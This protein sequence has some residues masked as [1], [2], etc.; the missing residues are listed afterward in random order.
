MAK[1][2][3]IID[4]LGYNY[5]RNKNSITGGYNKKYKLLQFQ[6]AYNSILKFFEDKLDEKDELY[7]MIKD[8]YDFHLKRKKEEFEIN[9]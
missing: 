9:E 8:Y 4:Y 7:L 2:V 6:K 5:Y 3:V 1:K